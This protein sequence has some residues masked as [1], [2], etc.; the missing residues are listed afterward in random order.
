MK[1]RIALIAALFI[2]ATP[3]MA[4]VQP[5]TPSS[6]HAPAPAAPKTAASAPTVTEKLDPAKEA[7]IRHL[8]EITEISKMG[9]SLTTAITARVRDGMS[10]SGTLPADQLPKFMDTFSQKFAVA[11]PPSGVTNA[12]IPIYAKN[13]TMEEIQGLIKFYES[14]VGQRAVKVLPGVVQQSQEAGVELDRPIMFSIL[15]SM[16]GEYPQLKQMLGPDP[17]A[18]AGDAGSGADQPPAKLTPA[19]SNPP[20][21]STPPKN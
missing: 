14:P 2:S 5:G 9:D 4:Q 16:Q 21:S 11:A 20:D 18:P 10:K 15:R 8:M 7:A 17:S 6:Q 1:L 12:I 13:F 3:V 19:P